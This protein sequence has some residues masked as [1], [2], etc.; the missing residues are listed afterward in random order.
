MK[1][2]TASPHETGR[3]LESVEIHEV[4]SN[5]RRQMVIK[6]LQNSDEELTIRELSEQIAELETGENPA[7]R[8]IRQSAYVSL[9]QTHLPKLEELDVIE[10]DDTSKT[11]QLSASARQVS[12]FIENDDENFLG[13]VI[14]SRSRPYFELI[15]SLGGVLIIM[16]SWMDAKIIQETHLLGITLLLLLGIACINVIDIILHSSIFNFLKFK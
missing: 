15:M 10:Y 7:P 12:N 3:E 8:N 14:G 16:I 1:N 5:E 13:A 6:I 4:L 11:A 9:I 2:P